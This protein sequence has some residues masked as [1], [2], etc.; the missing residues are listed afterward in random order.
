[1][2]VIAAIIVA[3]LITQ[4]G[5][6]REDTG[7]AGPDSF[8]YPLKIWVE[9]FSL[10]LVTNQTEKDTMMLDLA[11]RRLAEAE[12]FENDSRAFKRA[13]EEYADQMEE[14]HEIIKKDT[15]NATAHMRAGIKE[16]IENHMNRTKALKSQGRISVIQQSIIEAGSGESRIAVSAVNGNVSVHTEGGNATITRD[17]D[18]VTVV[19]VTN[20][21]R[22][23]VVISSSQ[24]NSRSSQVSVRSE[25]YAEG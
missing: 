6:A 22:Q 17:G 21:S 8:L 10:S 12:E 2:R 18:D 24:S 1:M 15:D 16:R 3:L 19:S 20:N 7:W 25:A 23:I 14:L 4:T 11:E 5:A 9:K 13:T